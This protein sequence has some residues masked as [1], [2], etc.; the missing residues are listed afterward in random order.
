MASGQGQTIILGN[1]FARAKAKRLIDIAPAGAVLNIRE[2]TR[3][4]DQNSKMWA[5]LSD[6]SRAKPQGRVATPEVWKALFMHA[7][8][9]AVQFEMGLNGQPFPTGFKSSALSKSQ[10]SDLIELIYAFGAE[11]DVTW[12]EPTRN[13]A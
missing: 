13:A 5:M 12:T 1:D 4:A 8:G 11:H 6:V 3:T 2:A 9:H 10:M 7:C